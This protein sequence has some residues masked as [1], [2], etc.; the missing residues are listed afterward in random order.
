MFD[1][2][3]FGCGSY[4]D[5]RRYVFQSALKYFPNIDLYEVFNYSIDYIINSLGYDSDLFDKYDK[6]VL[7]YEYNP[8]IK[9]TTERIGKK[10]QWITMYNVL[11]RISDKY[12]KKEPYSDEELEVYS[13]PWSPY[14]RDFDP[15]LN[16]NNMDLNKYIRPKGFLYN[17]EDI[18][19]ILK[20]EEDENYWLNEYP[21]FFDYQKLNMLITDEENNKW[22]VLLKH[23]DANKGELYKQL[24]IRNGIYGYFVKEEQYQKLKEYADNNKDLISSD[25]IYI[26]SRYELFNREYPWF[27]SSNDLGNLSWKTIKL[28]TGKKI[29]KEIPIP[30]IFNDDEL[31]ENLYSEENDKVEE[32]FY[33]IKVDETDDIGEVLCTG[34]NIIWE[35][36]Y[37]KSKK[38]TISYYALCKDFIQD[39]SLCYG[40]LDGVFYDSERKIASFDISY[41]SSDLG[42][43]V[44]KDILDKFLEKNNYYL[45]YFVQGRKEI[46][47]EKGYISKYS[48]W[49]GLLEYNDDIVGNIHIVKE[50]K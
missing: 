17:N 19:H 44:R 3:K 5:F 14:V 6:M 16:E 34:V 21:K 30:T 37:D 24:Q 27:E 4:G 23:S 7:N 28:K 40:E 35:E 33:T 10:Y 39:M 25:V 47:N 26:P 22:I 18:K 29:N 11:A 46:H 48:D 32:K 36:E 42:L 43:A 2:E 38:D 49:T 50:N 1:I 13:G 31:E 12:R 9:S 41:I 45:V 15:T 20:T 8:Y